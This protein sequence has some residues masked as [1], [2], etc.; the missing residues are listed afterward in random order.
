MVE[1]LTRVLERT[2]WPQESTRELE[3]GRAE[4]SNLSSGDLPRFFVSTEMETFS[5][6]SEGKENYSMREA[7]CVGL[8]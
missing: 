2:C 3:L 6:K 4:I 5:R 1:N 8:R 7:C